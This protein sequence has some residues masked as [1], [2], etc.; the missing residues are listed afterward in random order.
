MMQEV[1]LK[2]EEGKDCYKAKIHV[3]H[4]KGIVAEIYSRRKLE[5]MV[6]RRGSEDDFV[7]LLDCLYKELQAAFKLL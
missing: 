3:G 7:E 6:D 2:R 1:M 5:I 4:A